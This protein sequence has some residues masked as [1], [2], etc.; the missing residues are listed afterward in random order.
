MSTAVLQEGKGFPAKPPNL[1]LITTGPT[2]ALSTDTRGLVISGHNKIIIS[3]GAY[4]GI[5]LSMKVFVTSWDFIWWERSGTRINQRNTKS[6]S[7]LQWQEKAST[8]D[9]TFEANLLWIICVI[10]LK[11]DE[12][13]WTWQNCKEDQ[14]GLKSSQRLYAETWLT[15]LENILTTIKHLKEVF[16]K[17]WYFIS[18]PFARPWKWY[19]KHFS[20]I[21]GITLFLKEDKSIII[22]IRK[23][24]FVFT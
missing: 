14:Y 1:T 23:M 20:L 2:A 12:K 9:V 24:S 6:K 19:V 11:D 22:D 17:I 4:F 21:F 7:R 3:Y 8:E 18:Y 10:N 15:E 16:F 13:L 5:V